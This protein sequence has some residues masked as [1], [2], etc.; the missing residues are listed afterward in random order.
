MLEYVSQPDL[1]IGEIHRV[2]KP[3]GVLLLS[4]PGVCPTDAEEE[5]WRVLPAGLRFLLASFTRVEVAA[6]GSSVAG[7]FSTVNRCLD[8][9]MRYPALRYLYRRSLAPSLNLAGAVLDA[10][11]TRRN[12]Q[13]VANY[14]VRAEK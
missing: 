6:E 14:S 11:G 7:F 10:V 8:I 2:L 4:V 3:G 5:C 13:F 12:Q 9:F 1:V